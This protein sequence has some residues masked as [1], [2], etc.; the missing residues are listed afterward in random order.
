M[1]DN[2]GKAMVMA[3]FL[4]D[5]L[6]LGVH[7]IYNT[8]IISQNHGKIED[9]IKPGP[10]SYH[11]TKEKGDFTHYGDQMLVLL[12]SIA[13]IKAFDLHDFSDR[14]RRLFKNYQGYI[15]QATRGTLSGYAS[16]KTP[17]DAGSFSDELAGASRISPVVYL[18]RNDLEKL[19][20]A[21]R[22]QTIMT[23]NSP[24][25]VESAEFFSRV[26]WQVLN[27][28]APVDAIK[29]VAEE[30]APDSA[31]N[32]WV[33][34]GIGSKDMDTIQAVSRFGQSCH[35]QEAF[36]G[37]IYLIARYE[38][39]LKEALI[40]AVMAGGD[41]AARGMMTGMVLGAYLGPESLPKAWLSGL[42]KQKE[43]S[44]FLDQIQ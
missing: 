15:D 19:I 32:S 40:Q 9:F 35:T 24:G 7:W 33:Q 38:N 5:A 43:I 20:H 11:P 10:N 25:T 8:K 22:Y 23:H 26:T 42:K 17:K 18:Y 37:V 34:A 30:W 4:A 1:I 31:I 6:A 13:E 28:M 2:N 41:S 44:A 16:Q 21:A 3:A 14:W 27:G 36:P 39:D 29:H 12:E